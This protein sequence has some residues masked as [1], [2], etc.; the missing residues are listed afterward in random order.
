MLAAVLS[1]I[2]LGLIRF[3]VHRESIFLHLKNGE[4]EICVSVRTRKAVTQLLGWCKNAGFVPGFVAKFCHLG[5]CSACFC[6][7]RDK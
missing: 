3:N 1:D 6:I 5:V 2:M 7:L 4:L